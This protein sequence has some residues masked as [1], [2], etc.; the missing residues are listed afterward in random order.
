M[1]DKAKWLAS[2]HR[3]I[4]EEYKHQK[5][6]HEELR[7]RIRDVTGS[8]NNRTSQ[9]QVLK[10]RCEEVK[11]HLTDAMADD[12]TIAAF[13]E[14]ERSRY[15]KLR[16][17]VE[18]HKATVTRAV[19]QKQT[20]AVKAV[21][22]SPSYVRCSRECELDEKERQLAD[23]RRKLAKR[24]QAIVIRKNHN[25]ARIVR[26]RK[27]LQSNEEKRALYKEQLAALRSKASRR[28]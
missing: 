6:K 22:I 1:D 7:R 25:A 11:L 14:L 27:L 26:L 10:K 16:Q 19:E 23:Q 8:L 18:E 12:K 20:S 2:E 13:H 5:T 15:A 17:A 9:L 3:R 21:E 4:M 28:Y 24:E